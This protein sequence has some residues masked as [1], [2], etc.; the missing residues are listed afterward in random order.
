M[1]FKGI[2]LFFISSMYAVT[3]YRLQDP[4]I[5]NLPTPAKLQTRDIEYPN[6][7]LKLTYHI[8]PGNYHTWG[9]DIMVN[10]KIYIHQPMQPGLAGN[11]GFSNRTKAAYV[12]RLVIAKI[13]KKIIPPTVT[14]D[15]LKQ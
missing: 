12:A 8:I 5:Q 11:I 7:N 14:S 6:G 1:N 9:Y 3:S 2:L 10:G 4:I 13:R 15:E